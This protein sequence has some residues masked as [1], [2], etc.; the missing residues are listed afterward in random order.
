MLGKLIKYDIKSNL[1]IMGGIYIFVAVMAAFTA[2]V[3]II[4]NA[5]INNFIIFVADKLFTSMYYIGIVAM[6]VATAIVIIMRY[7]NNVLKDEGYLTH[8]LPVKESAIYFSKVISSVIWI[9]FDLAVIALSACIATRSL[10]PI[11]DIFHVVSTSVDASENIAL[12]AGFFASFFFLVFA[13]IITMITMFYFSLTIGYT[14]FSGGVNKDIMSILTYIV[15]YI[16]TQVVSVATIVG[17][18]YMKKDVLSATEL[19]SN[20]SEITSMF[21]GFMAAEGIIMLIFMAVL[22]AVSLLLLNKKLNLE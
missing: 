14:I 7:R 2:F 19:L 11:T 13:A 12:N 5:N 21:S 20:G 15:M 16:I 17:Y 8:T 4:Y 18:A 10:E 6:F 3:D 9:V 1:H 22:T